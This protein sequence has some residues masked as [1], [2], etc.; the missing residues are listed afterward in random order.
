MVNLHI[1]F[2]IFEYDTLCS[3]SH[4]QVADSLEFTCT[5]KVAIHFCFTISVSNTYEQKEITRLDYIFAMQVWTKTLQKSKHYFKRY[6]ENTS[7]CLC[8]TY[9]VQIIRS[10][11]QKFYSDIINKGMPWY[12]FEITLQSYNTWLTIYFS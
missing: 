4:T 12:A 8:L 2:A 3:S 5:L 9:C 1:S 6:C 10:T 7:T 11:Y